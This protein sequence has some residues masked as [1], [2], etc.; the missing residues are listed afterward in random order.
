MDPKF[1]PEL[2]ILGSLD[3]KFGC[4]VYINAFIL[5]VLTYIENMAVC[6]SFINKKK[7]LAYRGGI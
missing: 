2:I 5:I 4:K 1:I 7:L 3:S 6:H